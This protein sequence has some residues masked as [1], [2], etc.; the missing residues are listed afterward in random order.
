MAARRQ[1]SDRPRL[2]KMKYC[3]VHPTKEIDLDFWKNPESILGVV[4]E[5]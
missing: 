4:D 3:M 5:M 1:H 2:E